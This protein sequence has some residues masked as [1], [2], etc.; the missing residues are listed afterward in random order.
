MIVQ[1]TTDNFFSQY[2]YVIYISDMTIKL[3]IYY[4]VETFALKSRRK[5]WAENRLETRALKIRD[6][7]DDSQHSYARK[8]RL[9]KTA[10]ISAITDRKL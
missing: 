6:V 3:D 1:I 9:K 10:G 5:W 2:I 8:T 7:A 4:C